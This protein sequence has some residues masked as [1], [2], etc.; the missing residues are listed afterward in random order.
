MQWRA[1]LRKFFARDYGVA[2]GFMRVY[3]FRPGEGI[4]IND[5]LRAERIVK[6]QLERVR[7]EAEKRN[8]LAQMD[9]IKSR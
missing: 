2:L 7:L 6:R 3:R 1:R 4:Y 8:L 9:S 5:A